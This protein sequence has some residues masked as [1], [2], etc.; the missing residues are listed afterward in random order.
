MAISSQPPSLPNYTNPKSSDVQSAD[1]DVVL[2]NPEELPADVQEM[3]VLQAIGGSELIQ[4]AR[5]N[6]VDGQKV[7][8]QPIVNMDSFAAQFSPVLIVGNAP[9]LNGLK[10]SVPINI[11]SYL[12]IAQ[13]NSGAIFVGTSQAGKPAI[14]VELDGLQEGDVIEIATANLNQSVIYQETLIVDGGD[15]AEE[16]AGIIDGGS[17]LGYNVDITVNGGNA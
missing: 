16:Y 3:L 6:S 15:V 5:N 8:Y 12:D 4:I 2:V 10:A 1:P 13:D 14:I 17:S 7:I 9:T 11:D